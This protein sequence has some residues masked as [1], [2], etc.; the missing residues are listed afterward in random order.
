MNLENI[1]VNDEFKNLKH[2]CDTINVKYIAN[3][4]GRK[5]LEERIRRYINYIKISNS[6]RLRITER[7]DIPLP[8]NDGRS[9]GNHSIYLP[10]M[11][12]IICYK[13]QQQ[14]IYSK[15]I[16]ELGI[17]F[18]FISRED[19]YYNKRQRSFF[20][21]N[22]IT[23]SSL[24]IPEKFYEIVD[25]Q[26]KSIINTAV[27]NLSKE[28]IIDIKRDKY[29]KKIGIK[30]PQVITEHEY[31]DMTLI[32]TEVNKE[33]QGSLEEILYKEVKPRV[34][35]MLRDGNVRKLVKER[36]NILYDYDKLSI[37]L[38]NNMSV[39]TE[40]EY[41]ENVK[42]LKEK[43]MVGCLNKIDKLIE[44]IAEN[45]TWF[46]EEAYKL[47]DEFIRDLFKN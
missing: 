25:K 6:N 32:K 14:P 15:T 26:Y 40:K 7:Y 18:G 46:L 11:K 9:K 17:E 29:V 39:V 20:I 45:N 47:K 2:L 4:K 12:I 43:Y 16:T 1:N 19:S 31:R 33:M 38:L 37:N 41:K 24:W 21:N 10:H 35:N 34:Y 30:Q 13:L 42:M 27:F 5:L 3:G 22:N 28:N 36:L 23:E 44:Y 8:M